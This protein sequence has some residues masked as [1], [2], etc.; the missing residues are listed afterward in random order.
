MD[1]DGRISKQFA[2]GWFPTFV[3]IGP[4]GQI[5]DWRTDLGAEGLE[6]FI[7]KIEARLD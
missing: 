4:D 2:I 6:D 5:V 1:L 7:G 3:L